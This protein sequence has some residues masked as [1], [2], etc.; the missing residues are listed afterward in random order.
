M[1]GMDKFSSEVHRVHME[2]GGKLLNSLRIK[3]QL[4]ERLQSVSV[5]DGATHTQ[6]DD[7]VSNGG[8]LEDVVEIFV[9]FLASSVQL[10]L[11]SGVLT[12]LDL[13]E[14]D[15]TPSFAEVFR[16]VLSRVGGC[17]SG[18]RC[19]WGAPSLPQLPP[20][21]PKNPPPYISL[22]FLCFCSDESNQHKIWAAGG[23][24]VLI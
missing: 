5:V 7:V 9:L 20:A 10:V 14:V 2:L 3:T 23:K 16:S 22:L 11:K 21:T 19:C 13:D 18:W 6:K 17:T 1:S 8:S 4:L 24:S 15:V 12:I